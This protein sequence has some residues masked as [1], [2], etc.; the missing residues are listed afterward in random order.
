MSKAR[1]GQKEVVP[2]PK[3]KDLDELLEEAGLA[4]IKAV[5]GD[6]T[7]DSLNTSLV[8]DRTT[9]LSGLKESGVDKLAD[10]QKLANSIG[11]AKRLD[12]F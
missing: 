9:F 8:E 4:G 3:L 2:E 11:K 12:R 6:A 5:L 7:L 1:Y 10:R